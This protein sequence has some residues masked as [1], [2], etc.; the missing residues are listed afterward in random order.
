MLVRGG[1]GGQM[2]KL[3][4]FGLAKQSSSG[5]VGMTV[6]SPAMA[7]A[8]R[9]SNPDHAV[10]RTS[11]MTAEG[12]IVGT[13]RYMAPEQLEGRDVDG[14]SD[15]WAFGCV[16]YEMLTARP[17]FE[18]ATQ[19]GLIAAIL[20]R[21]PRPL[22]LTSPLAAGLERVIGAC[23]EKDPDDRFQTVRD[24]RRELEWL[25]H[26]AASASLPAAR[27]SRASLFA[28]S[29]LASALLIAGTALVMSRLR[30]DVVPPPA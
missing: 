12:T 24:V 13:F 11:A 19:A 26:T 2:A 23:L 7:G 9:A 28:W 8:P 30:P 29:A 3:L 18:A 4:D 16:L 6:T 25:P 14:R 22:E 21:Q 10:T 20:E 1:A 27:G 17:P 15:V 5:P